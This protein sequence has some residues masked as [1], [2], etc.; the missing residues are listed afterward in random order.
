MMLEDVVVMEHNLMQI[1]SHD[2]ETLYSQPEPLISSSSPKHRKKKHAHLS[3]N[4]HKLEMRFKI[5]A[6]GLPLH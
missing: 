3:H 5:S 2:P 6:A 4:I 1:I